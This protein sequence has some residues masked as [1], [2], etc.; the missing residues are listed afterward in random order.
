MAIEK[1]KSSLAKLKEA[2]DKALKNKD[3]DAAQRLY[4]QAL[5]IDPNNAELYKCLGRVFYD[6][7]QSETAESYY[8]KAIEK[9]KGHWAAHH[10]LGV[11]YQNREELELAI[12]YYKKAASLDSNQVISYIQLGDIYSELKQYVLA[13]YYL[14]LAYER[15]P[16]DYRIPYM[17]AYT[18]LV[19]G[20]IE[21]AVDLL[22]K[23]LNN[24]PEIELSNL[25]GNLAKAC[26]KLP[27]KRN[28][29]IEYYQHYANCVETANSK[30]WAYHHLF[31]LYELE[32]QY[33]KAVE[34][35]RQVA[36][37][38]EPGADEFDW[39]NEFTKRFSCWTIT[40]SLEFGIT[41]LLEYAL[42]H[43]SSSLVHHFLAYCYN[44]RKDYKRAIQ[45]AERSI[46]LDPSHPRAYYQLAYAYHQLAYYTHGNYEACIATLKKMI[47]IDPLD[48]YEAYDRLIEIYQKLGNNKKALILRRKTKKLRSL[49]ITSI[50]QPTTPREGE[51][52]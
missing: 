42:A 26:H 35:C 46:N 20:N 49:D 30:R 33:Q 48:H 29:A 9:D 6:Q 25:Y 13:N 27:N 24:A 50:K 37:N 1:S 21:P 12:E 44:T 31:N 45:H 43:P 23:A 18:L 38:L 11:I 2:A 28:K 7:G 8:F 4:T 19:K 15:E 22:E 36:D 16:D 32:G 5:N 40:P 17:Q 34:C 39:L 41:A 3:F 51:F 52:R 10:N 47:K 14:Q